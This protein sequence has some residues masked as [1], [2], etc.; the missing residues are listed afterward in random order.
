MH[1]IVLFGATGATGRLVLDRALAAGHSV[2]ACVRDPARLPLEHPRLTVRATDALDADAVARA[3]E[4]HDVV[5]STLGAPPRSRA[6]V[7]TRSHVN[8][9]RGM[10]AHGVERL[11][12]MSSMGIA[13]S[14]VAMPWS[15]KWLVEPLYLGRAF[16][17]HEGQEAAIAS[18]EMD[19]TIVRPPHLTDAPATGSVQ[20]G[21]PNEGRPPSMAI[22]RADV[23]GFLLDQVDSGRYSRRVVSISA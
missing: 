12:S 19:W 14:F 10:R 5:I 16:R 6:L 17:D 7:R 13:E 15:M 11:I 9:V 18:S 8:I 22:S 2:T 23:A 21:F 3:I 1:R 4:G 20:H